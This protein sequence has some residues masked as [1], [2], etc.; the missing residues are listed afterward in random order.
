ML[1]AIWLVALV[2]ASID[3]RALAFLRSDPAGDRPRVHPRERWPYYSRFL[4]GVAVR[5]QRGERIALRVPAER[6][7]EG[8]ELAFFRATYLLHGRVVLPLIDERN[9]RRPGN[10]RGANYIAVFGRPA[11]E[12]G[13]EAIWRD[14]HGTLLRRV[15]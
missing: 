8:Y 10:I 11:S 7:D 1:L 9:V 12:P 2:L 14:P 6:W 4:D 3:F 13:F 5:T 15:R